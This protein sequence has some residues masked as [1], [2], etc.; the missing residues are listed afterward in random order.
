MRRV[1]L[2][3]AAATALALPSTAAAFHHVFV[4]ANECGGSDFAG[5]FNPTAVA[6]IRDNNPAQGGDQLP[7][8]PAGTP[9]QAAATP[10]TENCAGD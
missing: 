4:P 7:L 2:V 8:P 6:A 5:G 1:V 10:A 9:S 3:L